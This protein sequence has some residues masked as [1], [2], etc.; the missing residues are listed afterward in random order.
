L[1]GAG[2]VY[3]YVNGTN[4]TQV[5]A[6][7]GVALGSP[8]NPNRWRGWNRVM[9]TLR[10]DALDSNTLG[11]PGSDLYA[12]LYDGIYRYN[13]GPAAFPS[14]AA[15]DTWSKAPADGGV[16]FANPANTADE[17]FLTGLHPVQINSRPHLTGVRRIDSVNPDIVGYHLNL[18]TGVF[19]EGV[20]FDSSSPSA[21]DA[22]D[23]SGGGSLA[24]I[25]YRGALHY[26]T[27]G[28]SATTNVSFRSYDPNLD[29]HSVHVWPGQAEADKIATI[30]LFVF[31][32]RL[33][34]VY[35]LTSDGIP[36]LMEFVGGV[37]SDVLTL[38]VSTEVAPAGT[39]LEQAQWALGT[40]D[41]VN[42]YAFVLVE[43]VAAGADYGWKC[44]EIDSGVTTRVDRTLTV[45]D[46]SLRSTADGG[47]GLAGNAGRMSAFHDTNTTANALSLSV[48]HSVDA[49]ATTA[50][51]QYGFNIGPLAAMTLLG[52]GGDVKHALPK[53]TLSSGE[54]IWT[55]GEFDILVTLREGLVASERVTFR[56]AGD[57]GSADK[58]VEFVGTTLTN[59]LI[60]VLP[61]TG[62]PTGGSIIRVGN[63]LQQVDADGT[64]DYTAIIDASGIPAIPGDRL[65]LAPRIFV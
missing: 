45:L 23:N 38:Q 51:T 49:V 35:A 54:R 14:T 56:A 59:P 62:T 52:V 58:S 48:Y 46:A 19:T 25:M 16:T 61:L 41:G 63:T 11:S 65:P 42:L 37:W 2:T 8:T 18:V 20:A 60:S 26:V 28:A 34:A 3:R 22:A 64:T 21:T 7:F 31:R 30:E 44:Y 47:A 13:R 17:A 50:W 43:A 40:P 1:D 27:A 12:V 10:A 9:Q 29:I 33:L 4:P 24:E 5:G 36:K 55:P 57:P 6:S 32:D 39:G 15:A 53:G